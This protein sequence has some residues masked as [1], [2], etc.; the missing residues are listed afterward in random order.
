MTRD[1]IVNYI[2]ESFEDH[3]DNI[4]LADGLEEAFVGI[5]QACN[6][7]PSACYDY[8]KCIEIFAK[9]M[10]EDEAVEHMEFNVVGA[11]VGPYTPTFLYRPTTL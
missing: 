3:L 8:Q 2:A 10:T 11:Y 4:L 5:V 7:T 1:E 9:D 6:G